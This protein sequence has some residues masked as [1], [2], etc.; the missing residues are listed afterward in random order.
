MEMRLLTDDFLDEAVVRFARNRPTE[1][2]A[3]IERECVKRYT[4]QVARLERE[5]DAAIQARDNWAKNYD[6][7]RNRYL[8]AEESERTARVEGAREMAED[9]ARAW[10]SEFHAEARVLG[11]DGHEFIQAFVNRLR[12]ATGEEPTRGECAVCKDAREVF[13]PVN[14]VWTWCRECQSHPPQAAPEPAAG[15]WV[16]VVNTYRRVIGRA[17]FNA[18]D[19]KRLVALASRPTAEDK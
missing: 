12:P 10:R 11:E 19:A 17:E 2:A 15:L 3:Y 4:A 18:S 7:V 16:D 5:R 9:I 6:E 14:S 1:L 8:A 13:D